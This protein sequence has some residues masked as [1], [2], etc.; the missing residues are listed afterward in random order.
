MEL[1]RRL[2]SLGRA[3]RS[4]SGVKV[5]QP[6]RRAL[7][8]LPPDSPK[9]LTEIVAEELNVDQV[10]AT[11]GLEDV[12]SYEVV[13]NFRTL[14]PRLGVAVNEVRGALKRLDSR[15]IAGMLER[16]ESVQVELNS[17]PAVLAPEDLE[18]RIRGREGF[19][20]SREG[21][22]AVA[23]DLEIDEELRARGVTR[24]VIRQIQA[25]RREHGLEMA[26]RIVVHL[27]GVD[28]LANRL[29][30][31]AREVLAEKVE[32]VRGVGPA[33]PLALDDGR[34]ASVWI[35]KAREA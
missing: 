33:A 27:T 34:Q 21:V 8:V 19:A 6:L 1:A 13:P 5:R 11:A 20:V 23:L 30:E 28:E 4:E 25:L 9:V 3:A 15:A 7:V 35:A 26:D 10:I 32:F 24:D 31:I 16:S 2:V 14:G 29:E 12:V 18:L 17:G 22:A